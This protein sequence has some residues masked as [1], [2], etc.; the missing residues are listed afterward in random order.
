[1]EEHINN[2]VHITYLQAQLDENRFIE[3]VRGNDDHFT[4]Q[5]NM[6]YNAQLGKMSEADVSTVTSEPPVKLKLSP[7]NICLKAY[8][9]KIVKRDWNKS[10]MLQD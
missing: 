10:L 6:M 1:M 9:K 7:G 5:C 3:G 8:K 4:T 2:D